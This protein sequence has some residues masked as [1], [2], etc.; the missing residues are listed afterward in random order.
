[1][2]F[3]SE[4]AAAT[5]ATLAR[6]AA[7][8]EELADEERKMKS[9]TVQCS[10]D[11]LAEEETDSRGSQS[12]LS[13]RGNSGDLG[14]R[15]GSARVVLVGATGLVPEEVEGVANVPLV[16]ARLEESALQVGGD[17]VET[18][19]VQTIADLE[20]GGSVSSSDV[21][22]VGLVAEKG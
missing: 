16:L 22:D 4:A 3:T 8:T 1:M 6:E 9:E 15:S 10:V 5:E 11:E 19:G 14:S 2:A 18:S 17:K 20:D 13:R 7:P 12:V 21:S